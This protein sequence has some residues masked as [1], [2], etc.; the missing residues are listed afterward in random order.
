MDC[1]ASAFFIKI[2]FIKIE[3]AEPSEIKK[4]S[5]RAVAH[6]DPPERKSGCENQ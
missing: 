1:H 3:L 6:C 5:P 4:Q 2:R